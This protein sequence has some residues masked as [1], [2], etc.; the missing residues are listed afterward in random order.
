MKEIYYKIKKEIE[1][2]YPVAKLNYVYK[3]F[4]KVI[5]FGSLNVIWIENEKNISN[6][7]ELSNRPGFMF[8]TNSEQ[9]QS[10]IQNNPIGITL[11]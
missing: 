2:N 8:F 1:T 6:M 10:W 11:M 3:D 4:D 7:N 5:Q 9:G